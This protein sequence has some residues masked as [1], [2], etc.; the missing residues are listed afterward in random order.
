MVLGRVLLL[1]PG[2]QQPGQDY[3]QL[4]G[5]NKDADTRQIRW[6]AHNKQQ[7]LIL[8]FAIQE[9]VQTTCSEIT[10]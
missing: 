9:S 7:F 8:P 4:L 6:A 2:Q 5:V 1:L 3:Y 10:S